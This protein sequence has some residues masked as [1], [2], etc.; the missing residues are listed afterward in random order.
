MQDLSKTK[1]SV[2]KKSYLSMLQRYEKAM[3]GGMRGDYFILHKLLP[4]T[5][6]TFQTLKK[7]IQRG[8]KLRR[9]LSSEA[10]NGRK[11]LLKKAREERK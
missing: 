3:K 9:T 5:G 7:D 11:E 1:L 8:R 10:V 2:T 6:K 4:E